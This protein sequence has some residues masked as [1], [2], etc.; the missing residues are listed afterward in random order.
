MVVSLEGLTVWRKTE[1]TTDE[2]PKDC[3]QRD[4]ADGR[5]ADPSDRLWLTA[6]DPAISGELA[7]VISRASNSRTSSVKNRLISSVTSSKEGM[8]QTHF[9]RKMIEKTLI[10]PKIAI[11]EHR[12]IKA[13]LASN[14]ISPKKGDQNKVNR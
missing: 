6:F 11:P 3:D 9:V 13:A 12:K 8:V 2:K 4:H 10:N 14:R 7:A 5:E 1:L